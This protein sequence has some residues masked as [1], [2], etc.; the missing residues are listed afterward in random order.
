MS[1]GEGLKRTWPMAFGSNESTII[2]SP[3]FT[4]DNIL[5]TKF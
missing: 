3:S 4:S 5:I 2:K 1:K